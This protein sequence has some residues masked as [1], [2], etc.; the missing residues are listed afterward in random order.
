VILILSQPADTHADAV[1]AHLAARGAA[2]VRFDHAEFPS[3]AEVA[4]RITPRGERRVVLR[5][6]Q[7]ELDLETVTAVWYRRPQAP[8]AA[9]SVRDP[10]VSRYVAIESAT[11]LGDVWSCLECLHVP[12]RRPV[13]HRVEQKGWQLLQAARLGFEV[14]DTLVCNSPEAF[15]AFHREHDGRL[16]SKMPGSDLNT[17]ALGAAFMRYTEVVTRRDVAHARALRLSPVAFQRYVDKRVE[18]RITVVGARVFAAE[19]H[20]Q[21]NARTRHDWRRYDHLN[22][23]MAPHEL[24]ADVARRC[25]RLVA[26]LGLCYGAIDMVLTPDG[27]YVFLELN[28]NGQFYWVEEFTGLPISAAVAEL[29][30]DAGRPGA[31][32]AR[33]AAPCTS[34]VCDG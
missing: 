22:T 8:S 12:A 16:I 11:F 19:I 6:A 18:L 17:G 21:A 26:S 28:P 34:E 20:S 32:T 30:A 24:P 10:A 23:P 7:R 33:G 9:S 5:T 1:E 2:F 13:Y 3:A 4:L 31:A 27:R 29:L 15:L 14:P 25:A